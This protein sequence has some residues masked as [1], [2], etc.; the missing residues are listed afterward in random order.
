MVCLLLRVQL[1]KQCY[2]DLIGLEICYT[3]VGEPGTK[4]SGRGALRGNL[5][6]QAHPTTGGN[7]RGLFMENSMESDCLCVVLSSGV[8]RKGSDGGPPVG[9]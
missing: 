5:R 2:D 1:R 4:R 8:H 3:N 6:N 7:L 9:R